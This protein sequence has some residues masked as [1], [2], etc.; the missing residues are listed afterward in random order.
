MSRGI[1]PLLSYSRATPTALEGQL[2]VRDTEAQA[3]LGLKNYDPHISSLLRGFIVELEAPW[4]RIE[5]LKQLV[6]ERNQ[7]KF[8]AGS[9]GPT[10]SEDSCDCSTDWFSCDSSHRRQLLFRAAA[11]SGELRSIALHKL[12]AEVSASFPQSCLVFHPCFELTVLKA[13]STEMAT[14]NGIM[15]TP[16]TEEEVAEIIAKRPRTY[17]KQP[18]DKFGSIMRPQDFY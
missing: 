6:R 3:I 8:L 13:V 12:Y 10:L 4:V 16:K 7:G 18:Q 14:L 11:G 5:M 2:C 15:L 17:F 9:R 1:S